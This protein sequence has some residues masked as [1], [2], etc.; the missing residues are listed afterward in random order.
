M[1]RT[2]IRKKVCCYSSSDLESALKYIRENS[3]TVADAGKKYHIPRST[4]YAR[5]SNR[6]GE[7]RC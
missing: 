2:Y 6:R 4:L 1:P 5:V 3:L 7:G